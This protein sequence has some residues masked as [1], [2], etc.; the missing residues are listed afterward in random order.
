MRLSILSSSAS[1]FGAALFAASPPQRGFDKPLVFEPNRDATEPAARWVGRAHNYQVCI[2]EDGVRILFRDGPGQASAIQPTTQAKAVSAPVKTLPN[3]LQIKLSGSHPWTTISGLE[4]TGGYSHYFIGNNPEK[5]RTQIPQYGRLKVTGVYDGIDLVLYSDHGDLEYDFVVSPGADPQQIRLSFAG[6]ANV[7]L[8]SKSGDV[9]LTTPS[10][11]ELR[12]VRPKVYQR[13]QDRPVQV[14]GD[15]RLGSGSE[16]SFELAAYD[17]GRPLVID[18]TVKFTAF[19]EG[20][21]E[22]IATAIAV[23]SSGNSYITGYTFSTDFPVS[24][25]LPDVPAKECSTDPTGAKTCPPYAFVTKLSPT[26]A[27]LFSTYL[28]GNGLDLAHGIAVDATGTGF[29]GV[30]V[31]GTTFSGQTFPQ[32]RTQYASGSGDVFVTKLFLNGTLY[33]STLFG[34]SGI[35]DGYAIAVD[36]NHAAYVA[37][38]TQSPDFPTSV[39]FSAPLHGMQENFG[40]VEDAFVTKLDAFGF[41]NEGYSTYLGG[42]GQDQAHGIS[43]DSTGNAYVTGFTAS[44]NFPTAGQVT[45]LPNLPGAISA[46]VTKLGPDGS[47]A[48]YSIYLGGGGADEGNAITVDGAGNAYVAGDTLSVFFETIGGTLQPVKPSAA[49]LFSGFIAQ[50]SPQGFPSLS[51]FLGGNDDAS[52]T[53]IA[54]NRNNEVYVGGWTR[55]TVGFPGAPALTPNPTAGFLTKLSPGLDKLGFTTLL[56]AQI[57]GIT[58]PKP[59][60][61]RVVLPVL[62]STEIYTTGFRYRPGSNHNPSDCDAFVVQV[63]DA[64]VVARL[65]LT[66]APLTAAHVP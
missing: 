15:Y 39:Y 16:A 34:G 28:G 43:V 25:G 44:P 7:R 4:P 12:T 8:D 56:G 46:F 30:Y 49:N 51:T 2:G 22:D 29:D 64:P 36:S 54:L 14:S 45:S 33:Y 52:C 35:D 19:L 21:G 24:N 62:T 3:T 17:A 48:I 42:S 63:E 53:S 20:D 5:W 13:I 66:T 27:I 41:L 9:V 61:R 59:V 11:A 23:D 38:L 6:T 32:T 65:P 26:G 50:V 37:G 57:N 47:K 31:T 1:L 18:P 60:A 40:G 58:V 10:G 55:T